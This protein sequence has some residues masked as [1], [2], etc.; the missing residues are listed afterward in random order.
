MI[1][2]PNRSL[3]LEDVLFIFKDGN[4]LTI[5]GEE[6]EK[7]RWKINGNVKSSKEE[8]PWATEGSWILHQVKPL[9]LDR[10]FEFYL[11]L[12]KH[13]QW[14]ARCQ[15]FGV[16]TAQLEMFQLEFSGWDLEEGHLLSVLDWNGLE[17]WKDSHC[18]VCMWP[19][20]ACVHK[21]F[22]RIQ[23][24]SLSTAV[25]QKFCWKD[26]RHLRQH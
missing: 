26:E 13:W 19:G 18:C 8:G 21:R 6:G 16:E 12:E 11:R 9:L 5:C 22:V 3:K 20:G 17:T 23:T 24:K 14:W 15:A 10:R 25:M 4:L 2:G 7:S 1:E